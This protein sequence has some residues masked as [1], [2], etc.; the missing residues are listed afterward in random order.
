MPVLSPE[1]LGKLKQSEQAE[2]HN[3][4][5]EECRKVVRSNEK[6]NLHDAEVIDG[7]HF[8]IAKSGKKQLYINDDFIYVEPF[9]PSHMT[10]ESILRC[11]QLL[12]MTDKGQMFAVA[13]LDINKNILA[14][15]DEKEKITHVTDEQS[16]INKDFEK[17]FEIKF[18]K[19]TWQAKYCEKKMKGLTEYQG[20]SD[21]YFDAKKNEHIYSMY[22]I[23][24]YTDVTFLDYDHKLLLCTRLIAKVR[25][26]LDVDVYIITKDT[27][28]IA[29][30]YTKDGFKRFLP[31]K[32]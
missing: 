15:I 18:S 28:K 29:A 14:Y 30:Q 27:G 17:L 8:Y 12:D 10:T 19:N 32:Y 5:I 1:T 13:I 9:T 6:H 11:T 22:S 24:R 31:T 26:E 4:E 23:N 3:K 16:Q 25:K 7:T 2:K 20:Y 21:S